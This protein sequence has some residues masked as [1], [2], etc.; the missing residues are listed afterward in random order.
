M[1]VK[2]L[3][4]TLARVER[5]DPQDAEASGWHQEG[6]TRDMSPDRLSSFQPRVSKAR[7]ARLAVK[8]GTPVP[9]AVTPTNE[10]H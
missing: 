2:E 8:A 9:A 3:R 7:A 4:A 10:Q 1:P 5:P 6:W